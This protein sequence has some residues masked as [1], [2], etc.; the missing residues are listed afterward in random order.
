[1][2]RGEGAVEADLD[3][4]NLVAGR[5][6]MVDGLLDGLAG[7]THRDDDPLRIPGAVIIE[8]LVVGADLLVDLVHILFHNTRD[9]LI[10]GVGGLAGLEE[11]VGVLG[12]AALDRMLRVQR[13]PAEAVHGVPIQ[14]L[15]EILVVPHLD[16][17]DLMGG[18]EA[19]EEMQERHPA[20]D[21]GQMGD[22]AEIHDLLHAGGT[23]HSITGLAAGVHVGVVAENREG[24]GGQRARRHMDDVRQQLAGDLIHV[25][26]H[27]Q[28]ALGG[29]VGGGQGAG[30]QGTVHRA[31]GA[32][33]RL[34]FRQ[35]DRPAEQ[36]LLPR[37]APHIR[38]F[39]HHRR[40]G[41]GVDGG[42]VGERIGYMRGGVV[43]IHGFKLSCHTISSLR[44]TWNKI[45][46]AGSST[47][48]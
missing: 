9:R 31:R 24:M 20:L 37:G 23:E 34:H 27:Q 22:G 46:G 36:V 4:A 39:R 12:G 2:L 35:L 13:V 11:D 19:V 48:L 29:G 45:D 6:E 41:D 16:F 17:L 33:L 43:A 25:G 1:M 38:H 14:H 40:R 3:Q 26:D 8:Q 7:G 5:V 42:N 21:G 15:S 28:K 10:I 47:N 30:L 44:N 32:G 18:A